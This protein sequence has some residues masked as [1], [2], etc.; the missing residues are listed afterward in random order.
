M[1]CALYY[2]AMRNMKKLKAIAAT[3]RSE[4]GKKFFKFISDH[5]FSSDRG[6]NSAEKNAYSLLRKRKY[7]SAASFFLLAEP[8]MIKSAVDVIRLQLQ[9]TSLAFFVARLIEN[10]MKS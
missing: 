2:I 5:D 6:R 4:S 9:D 7:A 3:D 8:P 10:A 1:D